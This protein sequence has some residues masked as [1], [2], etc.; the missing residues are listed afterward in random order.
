[1]AGIPVGDGGYP[2]SEE[3]GSLDDAR[4]NKS[5]ALTPDALKPQQAQQTVV[6]SVLSDGESSHGG[7]RKAGDGWRNGSE[8]A[9]LHLGLWNSGAQAARPIPLFAASAAT[10]VT[11]QIK[12]RQ[13]VGSTHSRDSS[14]APTP[15]TLH[16]QQAGGS[17]AVCKPFQPHVVGRRHPLPRGPA[18][19]RRHAACSAGGRGANGTTTVPVTTFR[20][21]EPCSS[22]PESTSV[23]TTDILRERVRAIISHDMMSQHHRGWAL[24]IFL[25]SHRC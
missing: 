1:M 4:D 20:H 23:E 25:E 18:A 21:S 13:S 11:T 5:L 9:R 3:A 17:C 8:R 6:A 15:D 16:P 7:S 19:A 2:A 22:A 12:R 24:T 10:A 14:L